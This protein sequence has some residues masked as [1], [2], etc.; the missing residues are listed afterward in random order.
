MDDYK[1]DINLDAYKPKWYEFH[2][3]FYIFGIYVLLW[4]KFDIGLDILESY[5]IADGE[6]P[7][8][9][10]ELGFLYINFESRRIYDFIYKRKY[11]ESCYVN[12]K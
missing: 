8:I 9:F 2:F 6:L 12:K 3:D 10:A 5:Y 7:L 1:L 11:G 4:N